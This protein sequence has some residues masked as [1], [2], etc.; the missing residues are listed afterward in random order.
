[1]DE[2]F[3]IVNE[4]GK[5][6]GSATREECHSGSNILHPVVHVHL[7]RDGKLYVQKRSMEKDLLPGYWDTAVG[8]HV[9]L[10]ETILD[11]VFREAKEELGL[12]LKFE[13][14]L[15][16]GTYVSESNNERELVHIYKTNYS[17][18][19]KWED[20]EVIDGKF[21]TKKEIEENGVMFTPNFL[22]DIQLKQEFLF[23]IS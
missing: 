13:D 11:A 15:F 4:L 12:D 10:G 14:V 9:R 6:I 22:Q 16:L 19:I 17:G 8:G 7:V 23:P 2:I 3:P 20:G 21:I 1:M 5:V 18:D